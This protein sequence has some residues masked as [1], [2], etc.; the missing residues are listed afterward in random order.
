MGESTNDDG[1]LASED[2][3]MSNMHLILSAAR[4]G[5]RALDY[6]LHNSARIAAKTA[7][8]NAAEV[9]GPRNAIAAIEAQLIA[10]SFRLETANDHQL[11]KPVV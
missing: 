9:L 3:A 2:A 1:A 6:G 5:I 7:L 4:E 10:T 11:I 8:M